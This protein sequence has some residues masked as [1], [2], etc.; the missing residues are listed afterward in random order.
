MAGLSLFLL[1]VVGTVTWAALRPDT[2]TADPRQ[3]PGT[4]TVQPALAA[5]ALHRLEDAVVARDPGAAAALAADDDVASAR[6]LSAIVDNARALKVRD[7]TLRYVDETGAVSADGAWEAAVDATWRFAGFDRAP[8]RAEVRFGFAQVGGRVALVSV[9]GGDRR[10]PLWMTGPMQVRRTATTLVLAASK[11][12]ADRY[13]ARAT[14]AVPVV[15]AVVTGWRPRLVVEVPGSIRGLDRA[16]AADPG[17]Y[18][19]IAAVTTSVD[20]TLAP[21]SPVHVFVNPEVLGRLRPAGAQVVM[22]HEATHVATDAA[23]SVMPIWLVEGFADY[24]A[25]RDVHLPITTTAGQII[26]QVRRHGPP[27][28]LPGAVEFDTSTSHLGAAYESAWLVCRVLADRGG[29][30]ALVRLY[31]QVDGGQALGAALTT[32]FDWNVRQLTQAW[33]ARLA[34]LVS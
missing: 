4:P 6:L 14:A 5:R 10:T 30:R 29:E 28:A 20:G 15:R 27:R 16:L 24:V 21:G 1:V 32:D 17:T 3:S 22:S 9:G 8:A 23:R 34:G 7:F 11:V 19:N 33:R 25:L 26:D 18:D 13:A 12:D 2:Y 31:R